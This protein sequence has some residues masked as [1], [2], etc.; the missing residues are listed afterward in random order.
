MTGLNQYY[1][2]PCPAPEVSAWGSC[3]ASSPGHRAYS[4]ADELQTWLSQEQE[5]GADR[6]WE[7]TDEIRSEIRKWADLDNRVDIIL[8]PSATD[9]EF[10]PLWLC[11]AHGDRVL[12]ILVGP[13]ETGSGSGY[14]ASG[15]HISSITPSG[16]TVLMNAPLE[17]LRDLPIR[18]EEYDIRGPDGEF[19][20]TEKFEK[21]IADSITHA[22]EQGEKVLLHH[23]DCSKTG[24]RLPSIDFCSEMQRKHG[25]NVRVVVD[26]AQLRTEPREIRNWLDR[27]WAVL[28][29]GSKFYCGPPFCGAVLLPQKTWHSGAQAAAPPVGFRDYFSGESVP[30]SWTLLETATS[31]QGE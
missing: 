29:S 1:C 15:C 14:A 22:I 23:V 9:A 24:A 18:T 10:I 2:S 3:T 31:H 5:D 4:A 21:S 28:I 26:A 6:S 27:G 13:L 7:A 17:Q 11:L 16:T 12:N 19:I 25:E 20:E 8:T 30:E